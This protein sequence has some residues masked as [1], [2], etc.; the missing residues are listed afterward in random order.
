MFSIIGANGQCMR[1]LLGAGFDWVLVLG[2]V[3][4]LVA[5]TVT[6][7]NGVYTVL[8]VVFTYSF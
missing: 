2:N 6:S 3:G 8:A 5:K 4:S 1:R 7:W